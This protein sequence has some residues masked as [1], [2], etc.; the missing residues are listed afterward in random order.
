MRTKVLD[1]P[2][3][4]VTVCRR[5]VVQSITELRETTDFW[6]TEL[7]LR[8]RRLGTMWKANPKL[9]KIINNGD[10]LSVTYAATIEKHEP[11]PI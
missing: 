1:H 3:I 10:T 11:R 5:P 7:E 9:A 4:T 6:L 2:P 8:A